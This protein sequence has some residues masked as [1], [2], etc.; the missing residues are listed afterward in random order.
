MS[1]EYPF[2]TH[3]IQGSKYL[4]HERFDSLVAKE[5]V[6]TPIFH[7]LVKVTLHQL[8]YESKPS[9]GWIVKNLLKLDYIRM[10]TQPFDSLNFSQAAHLICTLVALLHAFDCV[11]RPSLDVLSLDDFSE[12]SFTLFRD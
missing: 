10:W 11:E 12:G 4:P 1:V 2:A 5:L 7:Q 8:E 3:M 9:A 6:V